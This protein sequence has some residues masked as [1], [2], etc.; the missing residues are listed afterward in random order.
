M[1]DKYLEEK[2][3]ELIYDFGEIN[4]NIITP[5]AWNKYINED[6]PFNEIQL[7]DLRNFVKDLLD[8]ITD[9]PEP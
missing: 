5:D 8:S 9:K 1:T 3:K 7:K 4:W 6:E 2:F